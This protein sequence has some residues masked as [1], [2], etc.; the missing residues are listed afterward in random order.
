MSTNSSLPGRL[1]RAGLILAAAV[2]ATGCGNITELRADDASSPLGSVRIQHRFGGGPGGPGVELDVSS[3]RARGEQRLGDF[4]SATV[5]GQSIIGPAQ[6]NNTARVHQAQLLYNHLLFAGRAVELEW[7][8]GGTWVQTKW[9]SISTRATDPRLAAR[10]SWYGPAGGALGRLRLGPH[11]ALELRA[12]GATDV[13]TDRDSGGANQ[14]ELAL[15]FKPAPQ[16]ALR[17]GLAQHESTMR[18]EQ[19]DTRLSVRARGLFVGLGFE[20]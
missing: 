4:Q 15:A 3:V 7:F 20:F 14:A 12:W 9:E 13:S 8:V 16:M 18:P 11:L 10:K 17:V 6:I 1:W 19:L 5:G 2:V